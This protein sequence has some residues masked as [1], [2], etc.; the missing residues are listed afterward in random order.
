M[1]VL[2]SQGEEEPQATSKNSPLHS[3]ARLLLM[4]R[5]AQKRGFTLIELLVVIAIIAILIALLLPAVQQAREAA[6]RT[7][8]KNNL[9]QL[10]L[11]LHNYHDV[12][13]LFPSMAGGTGD[14]GGASTTH[15]NAS[16]SGLV[17]LLPFVEQAALYKDIQSGRDRDGIGGTFGRG[18]PVPW[19]TSFDPYRARI[20]GLVC[21]SDLQIQ[22]SLG[23]NN[24]RFCIGSYSRNNHS[25]AAA[26]AWG[27]SEI[28][29]LFGRQTGF[30]IDDCIDG[31]SMT[32][33][34][35]ERCKGF[36]AN[37]E[38]NSEVLSGVAVLSG[39]LGTVGDISTDSAMCRAVRDPNRR[40]FFTPSTAH[41]TID[42]PGSRWMDGRPYFAGFSTVLPPNSPA[43]T[44]QDVDWHW[45]LWTPSSRHT[46]TAQFV[47]TDG[48]VHSLGQDIESSIFQALGTKAGREVISLDDFEN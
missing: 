46:G 33:A 16:I 24:Y 48:S 10:G 40:Q 3:F 28:N 38:N 42:N 26:R 12:H 8:C 2:Q 36:G 35:G 7:Q 4:K 43:C 45:G 23:A 37:A 17:G 25:S 47:M 5:L 30:G 20:P 34:M 18:G 21:P 44:V 19:E 22:T 27:T 13:K 32:I 6:R 41:V 9:K 1:D 11:A 15:N 29:G 39:L 31:T 14:E